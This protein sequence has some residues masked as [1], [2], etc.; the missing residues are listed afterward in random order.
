[1]TF[2]NIAVE[3][4]AGIS[5]RRA[6]STTIEAMKVFRRRS[7]QQP[8]ALM[9]LPAMPHRV[10]GISGVAI[11]DYDRD[12]DLDIYVTIGPGAPNSLYSNQLTESA[13]SAF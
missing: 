9:D 12:G 11:F 3:D 13:R 4:G 1:M 2:E 8:L 7:L 5:Y 6:P 10:Y